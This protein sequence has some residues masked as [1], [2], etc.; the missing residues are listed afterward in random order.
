MP[1]PSATPVFRKFLRWLIF[2][3]LKPY[4]CSHKQWEMLS[5]FL[6]NRQLLPYLTKTSLYQVPFSVELGWDWAQV[7]NESKVESGNQEAPF[8]LLLL[9]P[10]S[11]SINFA[12]HNH[13]QNVVG[14]VWHGGQ[15]R[16]L[17]G[18]S[19]Q[20]M[21]PCCC[22][23]CLSANIDILHFVEKGKGE[24]LSRDTFLLLYCEFPL[25][26]KW[27]HFHDLLQ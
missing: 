5:T 21:A 17:S 27:P 3:S 26:I 14:G 13:K 8:H 18:G 9:L 12:S 19:W 22:L 25:G 6:R 20:C 10:S 2:S 11:I 4:L 15:E 16:W 7:V 1:V 23:F 24:V